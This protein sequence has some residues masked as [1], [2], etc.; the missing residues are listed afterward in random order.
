MGHIE[1]LERKL[2]AARG[3]LSEAEGKLHDAEDRA[4]LCSDGLRDAETERG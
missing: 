4:T 1:G 3:G 2:D